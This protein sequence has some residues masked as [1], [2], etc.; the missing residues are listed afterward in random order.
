MHIKLET[1]FDYFIFFIILIK[2][3]FVISAIGY[4]ILSHSTNEKAKQVDPKLLYWKERT[5]FIFIISMAI[6]LIYHFNPRFSKK[7]INEETSLLF[8][9]F[10]VV[11]ILTAKWSLFIHEAIWYKKIVSMLT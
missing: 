1:S 9:L 7:P 2:I 5:E 11:L 6:L 10:G 3:I 4:V 8:F